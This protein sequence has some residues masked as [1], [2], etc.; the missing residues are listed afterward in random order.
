MKMRKPFVA[1]IGAGQVGAT[2]AQRVLEKGISDVVLFDVV[3]DMPQGKAL[4][5]ME[6]A[7]I[8]GHD[9][10]ILGTNDYKDIE[11]AEI[12]VVTAGLAR[13]PGMTR[14]DLLL[15]NAKIISEVAANIR[16]FAPQSKVMVVTNPLD[17]M[18]HLMFK[19]T[20]FPQNRVFGMAGVL[21]TARMRFFIAER[22]DAVPRDVE[23][24]VLGGH[25]DLMVPVSSHSRANKKPVKDL[26]P[27][28]ELAKIEQR[29]RDGG[30][31]IVALLKTGSAFYAPA[32]SVAEMTRVILRNERKVLP[33]CAYLRGEYGLKDIYSGVPAELG[34]NGVEKVV[35][36]A[37]T[38]E[39]KKGLLL[40][41]D[42]VRQGVAEL[43]R[44]GVGV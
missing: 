10:R 6:A 18:T 27:S 31:E 42:K 28:E 23:A 30:A 36:I 37:L 5:L 29:T 14:E 25:G 1:I 12:V 8:E 26:I 2:A 17:I 15:M 20:G 4:D 3:Q 41:A 21:D 24:V 16:K 44:L 22:L 35:E 9:R 40:S 11:G 43:G 13:K 7:P 34:K 39:E 32:S 33:V 19:I 38:E